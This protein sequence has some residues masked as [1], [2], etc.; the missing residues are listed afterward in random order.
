VDIKLSQDQ[1]RNTDGG[2]DANGLEA[3]VRTAKGQYQ[4]GNY[5]AAAATYENALRAGADPAMTNQRL[6]QC[7]ERLGQTSEA[8]AAYGRAIAAIQAEINGRKGNKDQLLAALDTSQ[9]ALKNLQG[10]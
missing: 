8:K 2:I 7:Y 4:I 6:G 9:Q 1:P 5:Q 3:L 10:G